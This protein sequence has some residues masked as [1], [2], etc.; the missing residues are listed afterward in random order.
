MDLYILSTF[1]LWL[2]TKLTWSFLTA[3]FKNVILSIRYGQYIINTNTLFTYM[4]I[5]KCK[6]NRLNPALFRAGKQEW[7]REHK[8][9]E[10]AR[11]DRDRLW[12]IHNPESAVQ[13]SHILSKETM[14][15]RRDFR[16][17]A[18]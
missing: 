15:I 14:Y 11:T 7:P 10:M 12:S 9:F 18:G 2:R 5:I 3:F 8:A 6:Y 16:G 1:C 13:R 4:T 17:S